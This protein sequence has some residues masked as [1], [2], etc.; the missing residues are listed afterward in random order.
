MATT[1]AR[2]GFR[3]PWSSDQHA[4]TD[5]QS[6]ADETTPA[7]D[8]WSDGEPEQPTDATSPVDAAVDAASEAPVVDAGVT[9]A[10]AAPAAPSKAT[11]ARPSKFLADLT[12]AMQAAAESAREETLAR[13]QADAKSHIEEIHARSA[14]D[15]AALRRTAD[16]D[17]ASIREWSKTEIARIREETESRITGRKEQLDREVEAHAGRIERRIERVQSTIEKF[18]NEMAG[19]FERLLSEED[20]TRF[21]SMAESLPEPTPFAFDGVDEPVEA[22]VLATEPEAVAEESVVEAVEN[23]APEAVVELETPEA[24]AEAVVET[25]VASDDWSSTE[26]DASVESAPADRTVETAVAE[27]VAEPVVDELPEPEAAEAVAEREQ[28]VVAEIAEPLA[29]D[30]EATEL[31]P[32]LAAL[33]IAPE[34]TDAEVTDFDADASAEEVEEIPIIADEALAARLAGLVAASDGEAP[35]PVETFT[36]RVVVTGLV[37]VASIASFKRHLGRLDGVQSVGVTSGPEGEFVFTVGHG[38]DLAIRDS[39]PT[40]PGFQA[41][42]TGSENGVVNVSAH[43]PEAEG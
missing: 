19:F 35:A 16:D 4:P 33:G 9:D 40:L 36:T 1:D 32:R 6:D 22:V 38:P 23:E 42:V 26:A 20:P 43:D 13:V 34:T 39:V 31:D 11:R 8:T 5:G 25:P 7:S 14:D 15:A 2:T 21:A 28:E 24:V 17:V 29:A 37:S 30:T 41:R 10:P 18:E 12:K 27:T 3:L